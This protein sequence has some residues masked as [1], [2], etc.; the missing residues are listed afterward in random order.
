MT[1]PDL[2]PC[3][4]VQRIRQYAA[5]THALAGKL[6]TDPTLGD[7]DD[8]VDTITACAHIIFVASGLLLDR[9]TQEKDTHDE[10]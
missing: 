8:D 7:S 4:R 9:L 2:A 10:A 3:D 6:K 1:T 5:K